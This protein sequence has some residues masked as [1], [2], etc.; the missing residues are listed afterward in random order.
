MWVIKCLSFFL[1]PSQS[2]STPL[3]P[4]SVASQGVCPQVLAIPLFSFHIYIWIYQGTWE[5]VTCTPIMEYE[6]RCNPLLTTF[7]NACKTN[8]KVYILWEC[9]YLM[10]WNGQWHH[11]QMSILMWFFLGYR[12][13]LKVFLTTEHS[14]G[15]LGFI[16]I[17]NVYKSIWLY[18]ALFILCLLNRPFCPLIW[19]QHYIHQSLSM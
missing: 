8:E 18:K 5:H 10:P 15:S 13:Q 16:L 9:K 12:C 2:S 7:E 14:F 6:S 4:Q 11:G 3:Y 19:L 17:I 1:V